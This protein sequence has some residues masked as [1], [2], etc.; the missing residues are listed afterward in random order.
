MIAQKE[1]EFCVKKMAHLHF[2]CADNKRVKLIN[3]PLILAD[4]QPA[5]A[6][7]CAP[8]ITVAQRSL[9]PAPATF[10]HLVLWSRTPRWGHKT[11][12]L[13]RGMVQLL[14]KVRQEDLS[15][16][17]QHSKAVSLRKSR[18][19]SLWGLTFSRYCFSWLLH[20]LPEHQGTADDSEF[21]EDC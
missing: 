4:P 18:F 1:I 6:H 3:I 16:P 21:S 20:S 17:G 12:G 7:I 19:T 9:G 8:V 13:L 5:P 2:L 15:I 10:Q 14:W 11:M